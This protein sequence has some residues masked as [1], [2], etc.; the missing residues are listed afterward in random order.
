MVV[1]EMAMVGNNGSSLL[2][3]LGGIGWMPSTGFRDGQF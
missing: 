2:L 3:N 1:G